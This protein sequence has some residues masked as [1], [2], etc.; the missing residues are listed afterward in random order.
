M[1]V[2]PVKDWWPRPRYGTNGLGLVLTCGHIRWVTNRGQGYR[3]RGQRAECNVCL[4]PQM[5]AHVLDLP[6]A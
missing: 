1:V 4:P 5:I 3:L 6:Y 2:R